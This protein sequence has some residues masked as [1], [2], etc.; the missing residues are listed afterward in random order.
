MTPLRPAAAGG[1]ITLANPT[2]KSHWGGNG[3]WPMGASSQR[4]RPRGRI[5]RDPPPQIEKPSHQNLQIFSCRRLELRLHV[6]AARQL[7]AQGHQTMLTF[8]PR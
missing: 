7:D 6:A 3:E 1:N 8:R 2:D 5:P 4:R